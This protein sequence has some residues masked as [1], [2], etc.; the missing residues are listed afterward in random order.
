MEVLKDFVIAAEAAIESGAAAYAPSD[1]GSDED[2][3]DNGISRININPLLALTMHL[4][5]LLSC[6]GNRPGISVSVR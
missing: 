5:W 3:D 1:S 6:F 4:S 2:S